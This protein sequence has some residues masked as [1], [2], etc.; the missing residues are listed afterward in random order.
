MRL[1]SACCLGLLSLAAW[2]SPSAARADVPNLV[3]I[4]DNGGLSVREGAHTPATTNAPLRAGKGYLYEGGI[5]VPLVACWPGV[6]KP[7]AV[8]AVRVCSIDLFPTLI[9]L[10]GGKLDPRRRPDGVSLAGPLKGGSAPRREALFWH[11]PHYSNQGG[12]PGGAVRAGDLK[13]IEHY[14]DGKCELFDLQADPGERTDLAAKRPADAE[15]LRRL[16][17]DW[18]KS[19]AAQM[20][21]PNPDYRPAGRGGKR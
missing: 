18:R 8:S 16:L 12:R 21:T 17:R 13:L 14:E 3:V 9:E 6:I 5:R 15:R 4:L 10:A 20:P 1:P 11:H 19:V 2:Q 7:G